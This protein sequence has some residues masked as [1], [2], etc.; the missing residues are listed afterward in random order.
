MS[1][2]R[3]RILSRPIAVVLAALA[4]ATTATPVRDARAEDDE[5]A[6][7]DRALC[8]RA[9]A[10]PVTLADALARETRGGRVALAAA[11]Q[12]RGTELLL[13][14][15]SAGAAG[16]A[17]DFVEAV[18]PVTDAGWT[19]TRRV[20]A[21]PGEVAEAARRQALL[22]LADRPLAASLARVAGPASDVPSPAPLRAHP[23]LLARRPVVETVV[24]KDGVPWT[25]AVDLLSGAVRASEPPAYVAARE[26]AA[27]T[28]VG[29]PLPAL[30]VPGGRWLNV[31]GLPPMAGW[32][33]EPVLVLITNEACERE[34]GPAPET[35]SRWARVH[36]ARGL[37][38]VTV[39]REPAEGS[40]GD[41]LADAAARVR[42]AKT[43]HPVLL[44]PEDRYLAAL[45]PGPIGYP[46]AY[47][48]GRDGLVAWEGVTSRLA[49]AAECERAIAAALAA[50]DASPGAPG[51]AP[52]A[53]AGR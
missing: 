9:A 42:R 18:G 37:H 27:R 45:A 13:V 15:S 41:A 17:S 23:R 19:P 21:E 33:G 53:D 3:T 10:S 48:V 11:F 20:L 30:V 25:G 50:G 51:T 2:N 24:A 14:V 49:F 12:L 32:A 47:V 36:G 22:A 6:R 34:C 35:V 28:R 7:H 38:V 46:I 16:E 1:T 52:G 44:D 5:V 40:S 4:W 26:R 31:A 43:L 39:Y 8:E 29:K